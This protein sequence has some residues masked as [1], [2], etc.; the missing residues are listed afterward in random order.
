MRPYPLIL[1]AAYV[2]A[3]L[4]LIVSGNW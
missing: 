1:T 4:A 3:A 2:V